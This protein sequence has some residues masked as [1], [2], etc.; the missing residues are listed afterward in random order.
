MRQ[1]GGP[2][3]TPLIGSFGI[4]IK[5]GLTG[6]ESPSKLV[7]ISF[8][9]H[10]TTATTLHGVLTSCTKI[11]LESFTKRVDFTNYFGIRIDLITTLLL[12][13]CTCDHNY[14]LLVFPISD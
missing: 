7:G 1:N 14:A 11:S 5:F 12:R 3:C 10:K 2:I 6:I 4:T 13:V 8:V 9:I